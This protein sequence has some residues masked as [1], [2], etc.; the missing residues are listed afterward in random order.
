MIFVETQFFSALIR[1]K[2]RQNPV[3]IKLIALYKNPVDLRTKTQVNSATVFDE[4]TISIKSV[5]DSL[6]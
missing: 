4:R 2:L 6:N 3:L 1:L 5:F